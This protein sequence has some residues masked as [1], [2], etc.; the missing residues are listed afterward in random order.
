MRRRYK[1]PHRADLHTGTIIDCPDLT[2]VNQRGF[3][4]VTYPEFL[5]SDVIIV[6]GCDHLR[7]GNPREGA[8]CTF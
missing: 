4:T 3:F 6:T 2:V 7:E 5:Y 1:D 8:G